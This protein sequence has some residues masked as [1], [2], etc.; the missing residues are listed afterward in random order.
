MSK[1]P[2]SPFPYPPKR[3]YWGKDIPMRLIRRYARAIAEEFQPDKI[4]LF[5]SYAYGTPNEDSDV[6]LLVIM[7]TR[8]RHAQ[9]VRIRMRLAA[10][11]PLDLLVRTPEEMAWRLEEGE[12]FTTTIVSKGKVLYEKKHARVGRKS[13]GR[14]ST[15]KTSKPKQSS[16]S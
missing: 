12:C 11:F 7:P 4:I 13:R 5:G 3:V 8:D 15:G 1:K 10:P 6:D 2:P 9:S 14:L 16:A